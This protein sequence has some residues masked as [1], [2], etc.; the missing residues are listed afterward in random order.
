MINEEE[1]F[2]VDY[3]DCLAFIEKEMNVKLYPFQKVILYCMIHGYEVRTPRGCGRSM[4]AKGIGQYI[5]KRL[6]TQEY[7][8]KPE[9]TISLETVRTESNLISDS[10]LDAIKR[11]WACNSERFEKEYNCNCY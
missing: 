9:I 11:C 6:S 1:K 5:A 8:K 10:C 3:D 4:I 2:T 7:S